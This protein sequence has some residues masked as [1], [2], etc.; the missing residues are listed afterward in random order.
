MWLFY[1]PVCLGIFVL[2]I[3]YGGIRQ[4]SAINP[5]MPNGGLIDSNKAKNLLD[6]QASLPETVAKTGLLRASTKPKVSDLKGIMTSL[7][8][9]FPIIL[10]PNSGQR[11]LGVSVIDDEES[12]LVYLDT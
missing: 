8:L 6:I 3:R 11:G 5:A 10:K 1:I 2:A 12:A 9:S 7:G 4:L